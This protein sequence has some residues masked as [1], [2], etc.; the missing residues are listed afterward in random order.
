MLRAQVLYIYKISILTPTSFVPLF[1]LSFK[2]RQ[3]EAAALEHTVCVQ[4]SINT[5]IK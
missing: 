4:Y 5:E 2:A 3:T 1:L